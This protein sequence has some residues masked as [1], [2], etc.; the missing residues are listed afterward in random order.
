MLKIKLVAFTIWCLI[1]SYLFTYLHLATEGC[2]TI[3]H[4]LY[5]LLLYFLGIITVV[6]GSVWS[7]KSYQI[8]ADR[9]ELLP[10]ALTLGLI[11][12]LA[13]IKLYNSDVLKSKSIFFAAKDNSE[14]DTFFTLRLDRG[15]KFEFR[16]KSI[17]YNSMVCNFKGKYFLKGDTLE[18]EYNLNEKTYDTYF[19]RYLIKV[20]YLIPIHNG[21]ILDT[22]QRRFR[23]LKNS[24]ATKN[25]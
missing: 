20:P 7:F 25:P 21:K 8:K 15:N 6:T 17:S 24:F 13:I 4:S 18:M 16:Q 19:Y 23:I 10:C 22:P 11:L 14:K 12:L 3:F 9:I 1:L 5:S 2:F